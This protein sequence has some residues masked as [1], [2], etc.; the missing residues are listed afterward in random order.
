M[1]LLICLVAACWLVGCAGS[2]KPHPL[3]DGY[4]FGDGVLTI[5]YRL[6]QVKALQAQYCNERDPLA[7]RILLTAMHRLVPG[8]PTKGICGT[9]PDAPTDDDGAVYL[10]QLLLSLTAIVLY[11]L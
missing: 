9:P 10:S 6:E 1:R 3:S 2:A 4:G 11:A 8:Y 5:Y 7:R